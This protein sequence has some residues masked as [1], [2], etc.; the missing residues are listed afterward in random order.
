MFHTK[1]SGSVVNT[2]RT[3]SI[4][5]QGKIWNY[6]I[7][8][9]GS[10]T[11]FV[12]GGALGA[13]DLFAQHI[14]ELL[15]DVHLIVPEYFPANSIA[16]FL[17][18]FEAIL[19]AE[20]VQ[21]PIVYGG[22]FGGLLAQCWARRNAR[23]ISLVILSGAAAPN[24]NRISTH[25]RMLRILPFLPMS[26][27]RLLTKI[28][29]IKMTRQLPMNKNQWRN[30]L[31]NLASKIQRQDLASRYNTAMDFDQNFHFTP[32]DLSETQI[33][34]LE[35]SE[36][37]IVNQKVRSEMRALYPHAQITTVQGAGHSLLLT[38]PHEWKSAIDKFILIR[39]DNKERT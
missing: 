14:S 21:K 39:S 8:G 35:G 36:D 28:A 23:N 12:L 9:N 15:P 27:V 19:K 7:V 18:A 31:Q 6:R 17:D 4:T 29:A 33:L 3:K 10:Q 26:L 13:G 2:T 11:M 5:L 20:N 24:R 32:N 1:N 30:E 25:R 16:E 38:H 37:R 22:S 34:L